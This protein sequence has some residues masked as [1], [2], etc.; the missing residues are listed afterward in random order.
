[1]T[2]QDHSTP[3]ELY[4]AFVLDLVADDEEPLQMVDLKETMDL[5]RMKNVPQVLLMRSVVTILKVLG[6]LVFP[7]ERMGLET[8]NY[9]SVS[10]LGCLHLG[11]SHVHC[12]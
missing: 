6:V 1:M 3:V 11:H 4:H 12:R 8:T 10:Y 5:V 7:L 9:F 2:F